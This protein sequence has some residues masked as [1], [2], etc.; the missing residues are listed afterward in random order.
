MQKRRKTTKSSRRKSSSNAPQL[1]KFQALFLCGL[2]LVAFAGGL[3]Q[4]EAKKLS[5]SESVAAVKSE[6]AI[7]TF[8]HIPKRNIALPIEETIIKRG[9]WQISKNSASHLATSAV[10]GTTA[11]V[12]IYA[13][14]TQEQFGRILDIKTGEEIVI[15]TQDG[16]VHTYVVKKTLVVSPSEISVLKSNG[17]EILTIYTCTGFADSKRF[18]VQATRLNI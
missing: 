12:I 8:I 14:N 4:H 1:K 18:V 15:T 7:P 3:R 9:V 16:Q 13:H 17:S 10:P 2:L 6:N 11:N 5:F